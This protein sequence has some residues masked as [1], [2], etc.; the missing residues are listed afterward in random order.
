M[1]SRDAP[2]SES[3]LLRFLSAWYGSSDHEV[4]EDAAFLTK[5]QASCNFPAIQLALRSI[6]HSAG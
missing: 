5:A 4:Q 1:L 6:Q 2:R 3:G